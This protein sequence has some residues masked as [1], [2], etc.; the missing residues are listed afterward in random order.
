MII[1]VGE[2]GQLEKLLN[3]EILNQSD[4]PVSTIPDDRKYINLY[5]E[6]ALK[7]TS[8]HQNQQL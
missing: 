6:Q 7:Q 3:G 5:L 2:N 4:L 8:V 1:N